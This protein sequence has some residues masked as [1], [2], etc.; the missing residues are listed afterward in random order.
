MSDQLFSPDS[1]PLLHMRVDDLDMGLV[2]RHIT[3]GQERGRYHGPLDPVAFLREQRCVQNVDGILVPT[4]AGALMFCHDSESGL[5]GTTGVDL[6]QF[7][8]TE[9]RSTT[10]MF[11]EQIRGSLPTVIERTVELLWARSDHDYRVMEAQRVEEHA[12]PR[13]VLR[14][15]TVNALCHR[16]WT[17]QG[18]RVR[19]QMFPQAIEWISPG[20]LP[21][22]I[23]IENILSTQ[24]SRNPVLTTLLFQSGYIEGFGLG[25]DT[26]YA[27]LR[28]ANGEPP[29]LTNT[30]QFFTVRVSALPLHFTREFTETPA[31]SRKITICRYLRQRGPLSA[32]EL[33]RVTSSSRRT[34]L[35]DLED[36]EQQG[37]VSSIGQTRNRRYVLADSDDSRHET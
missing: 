36:L 19:I 29:Q 32:V 27:A 5:H 28:D 7:P 6:A 2:Q 8:T 20:S 10:M 16:D 3:T 1:R 12:Y 4:L 17:F 33:A 13:I 23:T 18:S 26:I 21:E 31:E 37:R 24:N 30:E 22:G 14:E 11:I 15:L 25:M 34:V 9:L 35:R